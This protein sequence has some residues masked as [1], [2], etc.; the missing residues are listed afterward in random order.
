M[1]K[2]PT[3][4]SLITQGRKASIDFSMISLTMKTEDL[5]A[6]TVKSLQK[7]LGTKNH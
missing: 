2:N 4:T 6:S 5:N 1:K 3:K 7:D